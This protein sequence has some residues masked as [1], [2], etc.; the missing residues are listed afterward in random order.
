MEAKASCF[1]CYSM[2]G[3]LQLHLL[4][5]GVLNSDL[6]YPLHAATEGFD[7]ELV[8]VGDQSGALGVFF[9]ETP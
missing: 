6:T 3:Y 2:Q 7:V 8:V 9:D 4:H 5:I 1:F